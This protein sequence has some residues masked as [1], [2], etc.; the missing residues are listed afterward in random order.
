MNSSDQQPSP[1]RPRGRPF[2][3]PPLGRDLDAELVEL[4]SWLTERPA[5]KPAAISKAADL[6]QETLGNMLRKY[7][8]PQADALDQIYKALEP[9][10]FRLLGNTNKNK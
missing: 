7:R 3:T 8:R 1:R 6:H 2:T 5:L 10:G 9:Y 4:S